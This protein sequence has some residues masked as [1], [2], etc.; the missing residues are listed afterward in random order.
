MIVSIFKKREVQIGIMQPKVT[1]I[2]SVYNEE[3]VIAH[4]LNNALA[5]N[6]PPDKLEILVASDCSTDRTEE[7]VKEYADKGVTLSIQK[8]RLGKTAAINSNV[9]LARGEI[10]IFTDA[11]AMYNTEALN[12]LVR[13]FYDESVG[14]VT[15]ETRLLNPEGTPKGENEKTY[16]DYD[17]FL[18]I[19]E[20]AIG[21]VV[22]ADGAIFA[23]RKGL[24]QPLSN[25]MIN[26]FVIPLRVVSSGYRVVYEP[27]AFLY[28]PTATPLKGGFKRRVRIIN[29]ALFGL[30]AVPEVLN[31]FHTGF[32]SVQ[33]ISRKLLRWTAPI[34]IIAIFIS[35]MLLL[36]KPFYMATFLL[37]A[38]FYF[39][40]FLSYIGLNRLNIPLINF[41]YYFCEANA[42]ALIAF[43]KFLR[44][45]RIVV[46]EPLRR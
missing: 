9:P 43:I 36:E 27:E 31:P 34:F 42:A 17:T 5:L 29:R 2:I 7:I 46:W 21:S 35:N 38:I 20:S 30:F 10:I 41:P 12:M 32:F 23:I 39:M 26:D 33:V 44:G 40:A 8:E 6:Y 16:Y 45:E 15:G 14:C 24:F 4:K 1:L 28:E 22:G 19:K 37:Q 13:N 18:K 11:N 25:D 3:K